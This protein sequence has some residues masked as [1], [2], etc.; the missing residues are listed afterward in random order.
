[1]TDKIIYS[2]NTDDRRLAIIEHNYKGMCPIRLDPLFFLKNNS[3]YLEI[4][5]FELSRFDL[6]CHIFRFIKGTEIVRYWNRSS[7]LPYH[8]SF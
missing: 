5:E 2:N 1:M 8:H 6:C 7:C 3:N 4:S